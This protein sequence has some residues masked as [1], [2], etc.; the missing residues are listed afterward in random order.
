[1]SRP[2]ADNPPPCRQ[3]F[4]GLVSRPEIA[5]DLA[6]AALVIAQEEY[7]KL[8]VDRYLNRLDAMGTD[9]LA[10]VGPR[11]DPHRLIA[12]LGDYLFR[13][14]GFHGNT[15][16]YYDPRNSFLNDVLDRRTGIPITLST[17]FMEV[18]RRLGLRLHGVGMPGHFMVKYEGADEEIVIDPFNGGAILSHAD[19]Q[20]LLDK[21]YQGKVAFE[22]RFLATVGTR[23]ILNRMLSNLKAIYCKKQEFAKAL[24]VVE[25]LLIL[26][27][28]SATEVRDRGLLLSQLKRYPE[29]TA[30]LERYLKLAP[31][32]EDSEVICDHLRSIRQRVASMN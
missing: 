25:R 8:E 1:M 29:A 28:K 9:V 2:S 31:G 6:E 27:P 32:A 17:V 24:G 16:D 12:A 26:E 20:R 10:R 22:P 11:E 23:Q 13:E 3:R 14:Q 21:I 4:T 5:I 18:G 7:P 19:C 30:D 15:D